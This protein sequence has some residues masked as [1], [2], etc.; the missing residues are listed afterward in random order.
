[1]APKEVMTVIK[2]RKRPS[3]GASE[4]AW[5]ASEGAGRA[6][7]GAGRAYAV[8]LKVIVD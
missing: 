3:M 1:M 6:S 7:E 2:G 5:R 4:A 8:I